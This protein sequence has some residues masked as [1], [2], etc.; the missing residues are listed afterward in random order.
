MIIK[1]NMIDV[2]IRIHVIDWCGKIVK[3]NHCCSILIH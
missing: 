2:V 3:H 1:Y